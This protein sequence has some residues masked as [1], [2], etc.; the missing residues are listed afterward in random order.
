MMLTNFCRAKPFSWF[1]RRY[2]PLRCGDVFTEVINQGERDCKVLAVDE[3]TGAVLYDY[4][5]PRGRIFMRIDGKP[6]NEKSLSKKWRR[7]LNGE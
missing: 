1:R 2:Q 6:V 7:L 5:M 4:E 3:E